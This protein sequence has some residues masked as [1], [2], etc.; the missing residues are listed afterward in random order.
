MTISMS[1]QV[2]S[3]HFLVHTLDSLSQLYQ[4]IKNNKHVSATVEV[5]V[6]SDESP[7]QQALWKKLIAGATDKAEHIAASTH[8]KITG[9]LSVT[10][11]P[12]DKIPG[13]SGWTSYP[14]LSRAYEIAG[15]HTTIGPS[16]VQV[17][18]S[19]WPINTLYPIKGT[20]VVRFSVE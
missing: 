5:N 6:A 9:I 15:W 1:D 17:L 8:H 13:A 16:E 2:F 14:P 7:Y 11:K 3:R 20:F 12:E 19:T 4:L 18:T 10:E